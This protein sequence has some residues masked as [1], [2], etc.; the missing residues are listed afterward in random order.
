MP[1]AFTGVGKDRN[2]DTL[3]AMMNE[4]ALRKKITYRELMGLFYH[5]VDQRT[6][7]GMIQTLEI[8]NYIRVEINHSNVG[9]QV[10]EYRGEST[11]S[12]NNAIHASLGGS[13]CDN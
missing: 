8:M 13:T 7:D 5:D 3:T 1:Q 12:I 11:A 10:I 2:A 9:S 6:F 4:I